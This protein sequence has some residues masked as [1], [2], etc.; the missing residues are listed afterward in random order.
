M[1]KAKKQ[2]WNGILDD[3]KNIWQVTRFLRETRSGFTLIS[4]LKNEFLNKK[5]N[6][7]KEIATTLFSSFFPPL[8]PHLALASSSLLP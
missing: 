4:K 8:P 5:V 3:T 6:N 2:D 1:K 7:E